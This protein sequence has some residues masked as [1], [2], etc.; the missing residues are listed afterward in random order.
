[1]SATAGAGSLQYGRNAKGTT[2]LY[3]CQAVL[4]PALLIEVGR[5]EEARFVLK[6]GVNA[7]HE[8]LAGVIKSRKMPANH[9]VSNRQELTKLA[10]GAFDPRLLTDTPHP[11]VP[12]GRRVTGLSGLT[13][14]EP[15]GIDIVPT[16][17][18]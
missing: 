4:A 11:F 5:K 1:V 16:T 2:C 8:R 3:E 6:H 13:A 14:F 10:I 18:E 9:I 15:P 12:A 17:K 7:C